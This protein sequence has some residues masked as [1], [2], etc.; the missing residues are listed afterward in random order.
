[1]S[2][3]ARRG[4]HLANEKG[5]KN[6]RG[7]RPGNRN[8]AKGPRVGRHE[9]GKPLPT[10]TGT[11]H[12]QRRKR[13]KTGGRD[14]A[15]GANSHDGTV[16]RRGKDQIPRGNGTLM[17]RCVFHDVREK[18]YRNLCRLVDTPKG[19]LAFMQ[20]Y[21]DRTEGR[22]SKKVETHSDHRSAI[23]V[24]TTADGR[25]VPATPPRQRVGTSA[26]PP[27][28]AA[29]SAVDELILGH[30]DGADKT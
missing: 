28:A 14:F 30:G 18:L 6:P 25:Q 20:E 21:I 27:A 23:F 13:A 22:P 5:D 12:R 11:A 7:G 24:F 16:F 19:A 10:G 15:R 26:F 17:L 4:E 8:G 29:R 1:M 9:P 2:K 3:R